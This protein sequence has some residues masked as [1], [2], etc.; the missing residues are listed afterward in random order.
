VAIVPEASRTT[1]VGGWWLLVPGSWSTRDEPA[2]SRS[3]SL[4][5]GWLMMRRSPTTETHEPDV[6]LA[7]GTD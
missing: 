3:S 6:L 7:F 5:F 1:L 4:L 2:A